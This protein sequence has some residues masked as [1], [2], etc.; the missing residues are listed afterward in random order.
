M[1]HSLTDNTFGSV[2][3]KEEGEEGE[4]AHP[5]ASVTVKE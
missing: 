2:T 3:V 5:F 1:L 4:V